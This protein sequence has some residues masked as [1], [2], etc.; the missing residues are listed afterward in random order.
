VVTSFNTI[1]I[2]PFILGSVFAVA[3]AFCRNSSLRT[4]SLLGHLM[5]LVEA[6]HFSFTRM[7]A[8]GFLSDSIPASSVIAVLIA[9]VGLLYSVY[10]F[11]IASRSERVYSLLFDGSD[12]VTFQHSRAIFCRS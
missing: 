4:L 12:G 1:W 9:L 10:S 8:P 5:L 7:T 6:I 11:S 2:E 3:L